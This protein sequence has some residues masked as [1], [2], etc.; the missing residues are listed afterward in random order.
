MTST[1]K[2]MDRLLDESR[3]LTEVRYA[4]ADVHR[5]S[6]GHWSII[7]RDFD[8]DP[9]PNA[10]EIITAGAGATLLAAV[11]AA[12]AGLPATVGSAP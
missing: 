7:V 10:G 8:P 11:T 2:A 1:N 12:W 3:K 4:H 6:R 5:N 9:D